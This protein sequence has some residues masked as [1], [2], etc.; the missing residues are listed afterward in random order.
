M[1]TIEPC[2]KCGKREGYIWHWGKNDGKSNGYS[3]CKSCG[4]KYK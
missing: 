2:T 3:E 1:T 4:E